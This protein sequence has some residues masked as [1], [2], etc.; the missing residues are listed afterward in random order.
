MSGQEFDRIVHELITYV[1]VSKQKGSD[2][3]VM[4]IDG[5]YVEQ[6]VNS[7]KSGYRLTGKALYV[8]VQDHAKLQELLKIY[9]DPRT[10]V[11][12]HY[13]QRPDE[14]QNAQRVAE[15]NLK[16]LQTMRA[17]LPESA[18]RIRSGDR[19]PTPTP[20][21]YV[22]QPYVPAGRSAL[23]KLQIA[24]GIKRKAA[25][26]NVRDTRASARKKT[27]T[28]SAR[29][30]SLQSLMLID[31]CGDSSPLSWQGSAHKPRR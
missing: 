28:P 27:T 18:K 26:D 17:D 29:N 25:T 16:S 12:Q 3:H 31:A 11:R 13:V 15:I 1:G 21:P 24:Q 2:L 4:I 14:I 6:A 5:K 23:V 30:Q 7:H 9:F 10:A 19:T 8:P 20:S 22:S